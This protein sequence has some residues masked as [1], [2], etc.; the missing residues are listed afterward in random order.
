MSASDLLLYGEIGAD[1]Y[2][3]LDE[4]PADRRTEFVERVWSVYVEQFDAFTGA[5]LDPMFHRI[6]NVAVKRGGLRFGPDSRALIVGTGPSSR[7]SLGA[8]RSHRDGA[9]IL[10]SPRGAAMLAGAGLHADIVLIEH[11][12]CLEAEL[13][14]RE[15]PE[16]SPGPGTWVAVEPKTPPAL[17]HLVATD[18]LYVPIPWFGWG[19]WPATAVA[20]ALY[21][22]CSRVGLLGIDLGIAGALDPQY[23][24]LS[25]LLTALAD[26]PMIQFADCGTTGAQKPGWPKLPLSG[27]V[28]GASR[29]VL[30][31]T[32][33]QAS[34]S[35]HR[36][37]EERTLIESL[38]EV[39]GESR[40]MLA[41]ALRAR[42]GSTEFD[43]SLAKSVRRMLEWGRDTRLRQALQ[44]GLGLSY[45]P[46]FWRTGID[47]GR[48]PD[49]NWRPV[50]LALRELV[51]QI[52]A[53]NKRI[54]DLSGTAILG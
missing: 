51:G 12:S 8:L 16:W 4:L 48:R 47:L 25:A 33:S 31:A 40:E 6:G 7:S 22:G 1:R 26:V 30:E 23:A 29:P 17:V 10:T 2:L 11:T 44:E 28:P 24:P 3:S 37:V 49:R 50:V 46:R 45:L 41:V 27:F 9:L 32:L 42:A 54:A 36:M 53:L 43:S 15:P 35:H 21:G 19:L 5:A 39:A 52:E 34:P 18:R 13:S 14:A 38:K 20:M